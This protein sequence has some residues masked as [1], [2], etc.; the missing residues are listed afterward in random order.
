MLCLVAVVP[1][2]LLT[3]RKKLKG[4]YAG[5]ESLSRPIL[6]EPKLV[7]LQKADFLQTVK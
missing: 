4:N 2:P 5:Q 1:G 7:S 6:A 3:P